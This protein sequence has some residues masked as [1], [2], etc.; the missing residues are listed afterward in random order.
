MGLLCVLQV[1]MGEWIPSHSVSTISLCWL[2][3]SVSVDHA[4]HLDV[5]ATDLGS[6]RISP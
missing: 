1:G 5:S 2:E 6:Q 3:V 4:S